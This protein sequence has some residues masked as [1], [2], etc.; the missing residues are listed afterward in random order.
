M[1]V[2][3]R[4]DRPLAGSALV[5]GVGV[6]DELAF[7]GGWRCARL[8]GELPGSLDEVVA[9]TGAPA[10]RAYVLDSD[11]A[12]VRAAGPHGARWHTYL[13]PDVAAEFN[14]PPLEQSAE[15]IVAQAVAWAAEAG[16]TVDPAAVAAALTA[17][18]AFAE[19]TLLDL[20]KVLGVNA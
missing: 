10:L 5:G 6:L 19:D 2:V 18:G 1:I 8:D 7:A 16:H 3:A 13:H 11:L 9:A 17:T 4:T 20:L 14:A 12:D 15:E